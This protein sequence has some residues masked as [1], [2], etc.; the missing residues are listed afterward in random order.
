VVTA[1][2]KEDESIKPIELIGGSLHISL[3][4]TVF[5]KDFQIDRFLK[6]LEESVCH[7]EA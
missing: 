5:L 3:S 6:A 1:A 4:K 2:S 7:F